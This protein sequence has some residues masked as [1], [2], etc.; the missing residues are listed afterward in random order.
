ML[1]LVIRFA[2]VQEAKADYND[3]VSFKRQALLISLTCAIV[4]CTKMCLYIYV[5]N[6]TSNAVFS[7][8]AFFFR[9]FTDKIVNCIILIHHCVLNCF[10]ANIAV[11]LHCGQF[12][13]HP[14]P[15]EKQ[16]FRW[17]SPP[18]PRNSTDPAPG[19]SQFMWPY[20]LSLV[21]LTPSPDQV[22][23]TQQ[24]LNEVPSLP[25]PSQRAR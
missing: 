6:R 20:V 15:N 18:P 7:K 2:C 12:V 3:T 17:S 10:V 9:R 5:L 1:Q 24:K 11:H 4:K 22:A 21:A 19:P 25:S 8:Y 13:P 14:P 16:K 23:L